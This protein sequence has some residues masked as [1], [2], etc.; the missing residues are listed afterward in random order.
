MLLLVLP[1]LERY[2]RYLRHYLGRA[3]HRVGIPDNLGAAIRIRKDQRNKGGAGA[4]RVGGGVQVASRS[5]GGVR[6]GGPE[7]LGGNVNT[8]VPCGV[9]YARPNAYNKKKWL[10]V[11]ILSS[12]T[13]LSRYHPVPG[14]DLGVR[15][16]GGRA[17]GE[18]LC[19]W[20][21]GIA[22]NHRMELVGRARGKLC[23]SAMWGIPP[24]PESK[25][26]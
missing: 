4:H 12:S 7:P 26:L 16:G 18:D 14:V 24:G 17:S 21:R 22:C 3:C 6:L 2:G 1:R 10:P 15:G 19:W 11:L 8:Q 13:T 25:H 9:G 5:G 20:G 23:Y